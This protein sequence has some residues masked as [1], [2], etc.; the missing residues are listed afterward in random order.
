MYLIHVENG[1]FKGGHSKRTRLAGLRFNM[2]W[3][4]LSSSSS[5]SR[6]TSSMDLL[7]RFACE[8]FSNLWNLQICLSLKISGIWKMSILFKNILLSTS[9]FLVGVSKSIKIASAFF[10]FSSTSSSLWSFESFRPLL[11]NFVLFLSFFFDSGELGSSYST[12]M[13]SSSLK[14]R[15][16]FL[17]TFE[18]SGRSKLSEEE[19]FSEQLSSDPKLDESL[20]RADFLA[21]RAERIFGPRSGVGS[22]VRLSTVQNPTKITTSDRHPGILQ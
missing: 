13:I 11:P 5:S 16:C 6:K 8:I 2:D 1:L 3:L 7:F 18:E 22:K 10:A 15:P 17:L 9:N 21:E 20:F 19:E 14:T 4:L 12:R